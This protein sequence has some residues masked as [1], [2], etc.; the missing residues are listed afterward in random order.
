MR[1]PTWRGGRRWRWGRASPRTTYRQTWIGH[2]INKQPSTN[3]QTSDCRHHSAPDTGMLFYSFT[4]NVGR[5]ASHRACGEAQSREMAPTIGEYQACMSTPLHPVPWQPVE[6]QCRIPLLGLL[7]QPP[8]VWQPPRSRGGGQRTT[9]G[10]VSGRGCDPSGR[11]GGGR[12][13]RSE[14]ASWRERV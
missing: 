8:L 6:L 3:K 2:D 5:I 13:C 12:Q 9:A 1:T 7:H 11:R 10:G 4:F 14:K